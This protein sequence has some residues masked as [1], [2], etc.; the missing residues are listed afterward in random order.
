MNLPFELQIA[1]RYLLARRRQAFISIISL[2]STL[3]VTVGVM[4]LII[5]LALM[6]GLQSELR[7]RILGSTAHIFV[8]KAT[9]IEDYQAE[10]EALRKVPR[11][12]GA[13]PAI[14]GRALA[15]SPS[16]DAFISFKGIDP[17]LEVSV[18]EIEK[19]IVSGTLTDLNPREDA[20]H[21]GIFLGQDLA[22]QLAVA[23]GDTITVLTPQGT[24]NPFTGMMPRSRTLRVTG[25][26]RLGLY[27]ID[28][29]WGFVNLD[30]AKRLVNKSQP[31]LIELAVDDINAAP[32]VAAAIP[33]LLGDRYVTQDWTTMNRTLFE[34]LWLEKMA[35]SVTIGLIVMVAALNIVAS[36]VLL[37]MEKSADIAILKTMG[38]SSR[39]VMYIFMLQGLVIGMIGTAIGAGGGVGISWVMNR[40]QL[41]RVPGMGEVYQISYV[42]FTLLPLDLLVVIV[43]AVLICFVATIYPSRQAAKLKPVEAL[44]YG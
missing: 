41:L 23:V 10:I 5:A 15:S 32:E 35:I 27:E 25:I 7:D 14:I 31:E 13:A 30:V 21:D 37:V 36:L 19:S 17:A 29:T 26:F 1:L 6:T 9:G 44:R 40:Y 18:T 24:L 11:V 22:K 28:N 3:G 39:S 34:A 33:Q 2:V 4:A 16:A 8:F 42:P 43:M 38:A 20:T 12:V